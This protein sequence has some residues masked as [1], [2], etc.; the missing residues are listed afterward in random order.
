MQKSYIKAHLLLYP[1]F[2][3]NLP[4]PP[5]A[6][7]LTIDDLEKKLSISDNKLARKANKLKETE[8]ALIKQKQDYKELDNKY[9]HLLGAHQQEFGEKIIK[10]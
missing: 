3:H 5:K 4:L 10:F 6:L 9:R 8:A 2:N 1:E 7:T